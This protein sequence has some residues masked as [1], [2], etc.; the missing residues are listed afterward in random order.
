MTGQPEPNEQPVAVFLSHFRRHFAPAAQVTVP[1]LSPFLVQSS[2]RTLL[3]S[4]TV[5]QLPAVHARWH[6]ELL[7]QEQVPPVW[8]LPL[9]AE[10]FFP[11][12]ALQVPDLQCILQDALLSPQ[13]QLPPFEH[14]T[15]HK[16]F[17]PA[18][19]PL[20]VPF[21][22][23]R[24]HVAPIPHVQLP[25]F[26]QLPVQFAPAWQ[27]TPHVPPAHVKPHCAFAWHTQFPPFPH[28]ALQFDD[29][30]QVA[31]HDPLQVAVH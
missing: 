30:S 17:W 12:V 13:E 15:L 9:H 2:W 22:H 7:P 24:S 18:Q 11:H 20:Q 27:S 26:W 31:L 25:P 23:L 10:L 21:E 19:T 29:G 5:V 6:V 3:A 28:S 8:Q 14:S 4:A 16:G 1:H